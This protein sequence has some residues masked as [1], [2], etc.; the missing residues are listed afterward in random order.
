MTC[1]PCGTDFSLSVFRVG[2]P[3]KSSPAATILELS[4]TVE[5]ARQRP[6][7]LQTRQSRV[8]ESAK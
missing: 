1:P 3:E 7:S 8:E 5:T 4:R 2:Q 6:I